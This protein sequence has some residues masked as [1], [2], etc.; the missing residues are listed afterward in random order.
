VNA[1]RLRLYFFFLF[2][3]FGAF[4]P[5]FPPWLEGRG[6]RGLSMSALMAL[7]P[8]MGVVGPPACGALSDW[9]G[10]RTGVL[11]ASAA[12]GLLSTALLVA[13]TRLEPRLGFGVLLVPTLLYSTSRA[14]SVAMADVVAIEAAGSS[15][16]Y[17]SFRLWGSLGFLITAFAVGRLINVHDALALPVF[18]AASSAVALALS[19]MV[20]ARPLARGLKLGAIVGPVLRDRAFLR[21]LVVV[22]LGFG[23]HVCYDVCFSLHLGRLGM[24]ARVVGLAWAVGTLAEVGL[25]AIAHRIFARFSS[26]KLLVASLSVGAMRWLFIAFVPVPALL[27][28]LQPLHALSF[29]LLWVASIDLMARRVPP[30]ALATARGIFTATVGVGS[31]AGMLAWGALF[32]AHGGSASFGCAAALAACAAV[33]ASRL[34]APRGLL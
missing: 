20:R 32:E 4:L 12:V 22:V 17:G 16:S 18:M 10:L 3:T 13:A 33:A 8:A 21:F 14:A 29:A 6:V 15:G 9:L 25:F 28:A 34:D 1:A 26:A 30:S 5:F 24:G 31:V 19:L 23:A 7:V 11:R 27:L 2:V